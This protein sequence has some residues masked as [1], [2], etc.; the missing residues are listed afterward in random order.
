MLKKRG[1]PK[2]RRGLALGFGLSGPRGGWPARWCAAAPRG[3]PGLEGGG[4]GGGGGSAGGGRG[5]SAGGR[6]GGGWGRDGV[7]VGVTWGDL[8]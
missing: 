4:W 5:R 2:V 7:G 1:W 3:P 8:G 6:V